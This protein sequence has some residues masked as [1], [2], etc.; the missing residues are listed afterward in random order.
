MVAK[1]AKRIWLMAVLIPVLLFVVGI[2]TLKVVFTSERLK[3]MAI[4]RMEEATGRTVSIGNVG[5]SIFPSLAVE[6]DSLKISN[7][8]GKGFSSRPFLSLAT[9]RLNVSLWALLG[10]R[11][12]VTSLM[13]DRPHM[14][15]EVNSDNLSNYSDLGGQNRTPGADS[16]GENSA[17]ALSLFVSGFRVQHGILEYV[18][19]RTDGATRLR[20]VDI[21]AGLESEG[22]RFVV[23]GEAVSDSLSYGSVDEILFDG[24]G[25]ALSFR[26]AYDPQSDL[27]TFE[28]GALTVEKIPLELSGTIGGLQAATTLDLSIGSESVDIADLFSLVPQASGE[29]KTEISGTGRATVRIDITGVLTDSTES[30]T[31]GRITARDAS[32][33]YAGLAR[34]ITDITVLASFTRTATVQEFRIDTLTA[35]LGEAPVAISMRVTNFDDPRLTLAASGLLNLAQLQDFYPLEEGT[36]LSGVVQG[37][38]QASGV[39]RDPKRLR[40][41]GTMDFR[42][43]SVATAQTPS[44]LQDL[45]GSITFNNQ[46]L[47]SRRL[48]FTLG[49][50][51]LTLGVRVTNYLIAAIGRC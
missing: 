4:P 35:R 26:M 13:L 20:A 27:L 14:L 7:R 46:V 25:A 40:A 33:Q 15:L 45:T 16:P 44:P 49:K 37:R 42:G 17:A 47:E 10:G 28:R 43:V 3:A 5:L 22:R 50:S 32:A 29:R 41:S 2:V 12:E 6:I 8:L 24:V 48:S 18:N 36:S 11:L 21:E 39:M 51:D 38:V 9:L 23:E 34:P 31:R 1:R 30:E 19:H